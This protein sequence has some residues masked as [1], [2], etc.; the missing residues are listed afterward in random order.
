[1]KSTRKSLFQKN[2][3][4]VTEPDR[5]LHE[6]EAEKQLRSQQYEDLEN[7]QP[8]RRTAAAAPSSSRP[9]VRPAATHDAMDVDEDSDM[10]IPAT[11]RTSSRTQL[12]DDLDDFDDDHEADD[13]RPVASSSR[14]KPPA[15]TVRVKKPSRP[16]PVC[17][18]D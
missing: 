15:R 7:S 14:A 12:V 17:S 6:I 10:E 3:T 2:G 11:A 16:A 5:L 13:V 9:T 8:A 4:N 18:I 1:M